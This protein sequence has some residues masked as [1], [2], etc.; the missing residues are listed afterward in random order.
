MDTWQVIDRASTDE[1]RRLLARA[2]G[3]S[4][5]VE[6]MLLQRP[7]GT[8]EVLLAA[9]RDEWERLTE[10]DWREAFRHHP[11]IGDRERL[12]ERF[13][14]SH[15]LSAREQSGIDGAPEASLAALAEGNRQYEQ[16]FGYIFIV[17]A[18]GRSADEML[19]MLRARLHN[20]AKQEIEIAAAEQAKITALRL[21][22]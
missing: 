15:A 21:G 17:C 11:K 20:D 10:D 7:F 1:A 9:A 3:A 6:R 13:P 22:Q 18:S 16:K 12:R 4:R 14:A 2:C 19:A 8:R 5:W